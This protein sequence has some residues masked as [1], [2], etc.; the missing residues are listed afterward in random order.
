MPN[1]LDEALEAVKLA[2]LYDISPLLSRAGAVVVGLTTQANAV[3]VWRYAADHLA[4]PQ[5]QAIA[6][7]AF[8]QVRTH[9][10]ELTRRPSELDNLDDKSMELLVSS[11][12]LVVGSEDV[13]LRVVVARINAATPGA[14]YA[15]RCAWLGNIR[16]G[17]LSRQQMVESLKHVLSSRRTPSDNTLW[18]SRYS[19]GLLEAL[20]FHVDNGEALLHLSNVP[21]GGVGKHQLTVAA[22]VDRKAEVSST[23]V[24]G[25][26]RWQL[27]CKLAG[28]GTSKPLIESLTLQR[29]PG[30]ASVAEAAGV[31][32][33]AVVKVSVDLECRDLKHDSSRKVPYDTIEQKHR[34]T[35][36]YRY[37]VYEE[38]GFIAG[39]STSS[40][41]L[42][43]EQSLDAAAAMDEM[44]LTTAIQSVL[45]RHE[46]CGCSLSSA[47]RLGVCA[48][49]TVTPVVE[50]N[51]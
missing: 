2:H 47:S 44:D 1:T 28:E 29:L 12:D 36:H 25:A 17:R 11:N 13:V 32:P 46:Q 30:G 38:C 6:Y 43:R 16:W 40:A 8:L 41:V 34:Q 9:F 50:T 27:R 35:C 10:D 42:R 39:S 31:T 21:R 26:D 7:A 14:Q 49:F 37:G 15:T 4:F 24:V 45:S 19:A 33:P 51:L 20:Y 23:L 5:G 22:N 18:P 3:R 48:L